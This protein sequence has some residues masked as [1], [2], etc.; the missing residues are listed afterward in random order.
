MRAFLQ[1]RDPGENYIE[2]ILCGPRVEDLPEDH[3]SRSRV[4]ALAE[5]ARAAFVNVMETILTRMENDERELQQT[6]RE[7]GRRLSQ[8][9]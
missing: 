7:A 5:R 9:A 1:G 3:I 8:E 4:L 6:E 2:D